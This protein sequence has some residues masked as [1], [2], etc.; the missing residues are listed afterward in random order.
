[1]LVQAFVLLPLTFCGVYALGISRWQLVLMKLARVRSASVRYR[2]LDSKASTEVMPRAEARSIERAR[3]IA[4]IVH[5]AAHHGVY[6]ANCL[7]QTLVLWSLL[8][9]DG[10]ESEIRFGARKKDGQLQAHA[11]VEYL[12]V[13]LNEE[14]DVCRHFSPFEGVAVGASTEGSDVVRARTGNSLCL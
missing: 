12:G 11:W 10:I 2:G 5:I 8:R 6:R 3:A 7:Q 14:S 4:R 9:R 13:V 1:M